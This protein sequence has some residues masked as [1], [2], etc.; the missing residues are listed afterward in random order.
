MKIRTRV[1]L[2]T[3]FFTQ[4]IRSYFFFF[5]YFSLLL[6]VSVYD[7]I[8]GNSFLLKMIFIEII[9]DKGNEPSVLFS[10]YNFSSTRKSIFLVLITEVRK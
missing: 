2:L 3:V 7:P 6:F 9:K 8:L 4:L 5:V 10:F 1:N